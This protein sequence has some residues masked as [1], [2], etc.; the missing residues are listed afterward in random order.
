M[1]K[2]LCKP[3]V[4]VMALVGCLFCLPQ[5]SWGAAGLGDGVGLS[6]GGILRQRHRTDGLLARSNPGMAF[7]I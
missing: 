5:A 3:T 2:N 6:A 7:Q 4:L 1:K